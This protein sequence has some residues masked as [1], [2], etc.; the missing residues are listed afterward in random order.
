M[1]RDDL[2]RLYYSPNSDPLIGDAYPKHYA[3]RNPEAGGLVGVPR[4]I[5]EDRRTW[6]VRLTPGVNRGYQSRTLRADGTLARFTAAF[7][8]SDM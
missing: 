1:A 3:A 2:G 8:L 5:A 4:R 7:R 6:P